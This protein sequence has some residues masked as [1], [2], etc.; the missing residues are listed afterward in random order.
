MI[1]YDQALSLVN[2]R[3]AEFDA[4]EADAWVVYQEHTIERPFGWVFFWGSGMYARTGD[5]SYAVG[6]NAPYIVN[7]HTGAVVETGTGEPTEVYI[8]RYEA[9]GS[10]PRAVELCGWRIGANKVAAVKA[11]R[12]HSSLGL[13][14]AKRA[15]DS[16]LGGGRARIKASDSK[17]ALDLAAALEE[18]H[19]TVDTPRLSA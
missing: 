11:I 12:E 2:A 17:A 14:D 9:R 18:L 3:I 6:G 13:A 16:V 10:D 7:R 19:F 1:D 8:Q 5:L 4:P 15:V